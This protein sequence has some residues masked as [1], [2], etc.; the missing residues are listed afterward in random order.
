MREGLHQR[1]FDGGLDPRANEPADQD[2][3]AEREPHGRGGVQASFD[4]RTNDRSADDVVGEIEWIGDQ[5]E[6]SQIGWRFGRSDARSAPVSVRGTGD[7]EH[8]SR[9]DHDRHKGRL[10]RDGGYRCQK[11][12]CED[13]DLGGTREARDRNGDLLELRQ[14]SVCGN[15]QPDTERKEAAVAQQERCARHP[16]HQDDEIGQVGRRRA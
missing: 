14:L 6:R 16:K 2:K 7:E 3:H 13:V 11:E 1:G 4:Q 8:R 9:P 15:E 12:R 10:I 5:P